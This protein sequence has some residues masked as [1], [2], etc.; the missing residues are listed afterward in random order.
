[1]NKKIV[2]RSEDKGNFHCIL[3]DE[4]DFDKQLNYLIYG[5]ENPKH[6][7]CVHFNGETLDFVDYYHAERMGYHEVVSIEDTNEEVSKTFYNQ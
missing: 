1:M 6:G 4:K 2:F 3:S 7:L 5:E